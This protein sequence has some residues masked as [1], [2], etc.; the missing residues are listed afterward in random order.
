MKLAA[1]GSWFHHKLKEADLLLKSDAILR[2]KLLLVK[3]D[4]RF[5]SLI[6]TRFMMTNTQT[7]NRETQRFFLVIKPLLQENKVYLS[8][9]EPLEKYNR[10]QHI[11][12]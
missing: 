6:P 5:Q 4:Q 11:Y 9:G 3:I 8:M 1:V 10:W 2:P 12:I 7:L